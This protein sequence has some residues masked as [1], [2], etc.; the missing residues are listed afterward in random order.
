[1]KVEAI[2]P[3]GMLDIMGG[4]N[5]PAAVIRGMEPHRHAQAVG[6]MVRWARC[7]SMPQLRSSTQGRGLF[8]GI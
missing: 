6:A 3:E 2:M 7:L 8:D 5:G 4:L 1:M